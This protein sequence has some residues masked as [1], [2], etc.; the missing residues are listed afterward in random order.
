[1]GLNRTK[2]LNASPLPWSA[3]G[4]RSVSHYV[5]LYHTRRT[6]FL[7]STSNQF[8]IH[9]LVMSLMISTLF[10]MWSQPCAAVL[11]VSI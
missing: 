5:P 10:E 7:C 8:L 3:S 1:M 2:E 6:Q 9:A 11:S 4:L